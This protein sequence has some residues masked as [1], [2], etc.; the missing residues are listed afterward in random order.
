MVR[1]GCGQGQR[2][3]HP[4]LHRSSGRHQ[5]AMLLDPMPHEL[6]FEVSPS[7]GEVSAIY[8][9]P[10]DPWVAGF[11]GQVNLLRGRVEAGRLRLGSLALQLPA[12]PTEDS[13][14][15]VALRPEAIRITRAGASG[16]GLAGEV[17]G[18][19]YLGTIVRYR[20]RCGDDTLTVD[21]HDPAGKTLL[22]GRVA[23]AFDPPRLRVWPIPPP[24]APAPPARY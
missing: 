8:D 6:R 3:E 20:V 23:L 17:V 1:A 11:V 15:L 22:A 16:D 9:A 19:T 21:D 13:E 14:V 7:S 24:A 5:F 10:A 12:L 18:H 2:G 4:H